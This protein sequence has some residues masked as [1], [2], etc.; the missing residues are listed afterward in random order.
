M[1]VICAWCGKYLSGIENGEDEKISHSMCLECSEKLRSE[2]ED[3]E[4]KEVQVG[5][6]CGRKQEL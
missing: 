4:E 3:F 2:I 6:N 1:L 5:E